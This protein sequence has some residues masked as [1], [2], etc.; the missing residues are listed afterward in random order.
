M[1]TLV[2]LLRQAARLDP[3]LDLARTL[4]ALGRPS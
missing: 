4:S 1:A 2:E 3:T